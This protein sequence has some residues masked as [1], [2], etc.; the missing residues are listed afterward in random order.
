MTAHT[1]HWS[2]DDPAVLHVG[3]DPDLCPVCKPTEEQP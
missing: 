1:T 3:A 2:G